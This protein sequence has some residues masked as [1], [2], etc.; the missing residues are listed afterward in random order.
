MYG[1]RYSYF[2][3]LFCLILQLRASKGLPSQRVVP[4]PSA[5][6]SVTPPAEQHQMVQANAPESNPSASSFV[7]DN[8]NVGTDEGFVQ[9]DGE[10]KPFTLV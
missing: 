5:R 6:Q 9:E 10:F 4:L 3:V 8:T 2:D 7:P 1:I